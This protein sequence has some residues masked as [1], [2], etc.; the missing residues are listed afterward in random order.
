MYW[1]F[2][3]DR[4]GIKINKRISLLLVTV[5]AVLCLLVVGMFSPSAASKL[6]SP[7]NFTLNTVDNTV[8]ISWGEVD[9]A[10]SYELF[11]QK[12]GTTWQSVVVEG[13]KHTFT[14][15]SPYDTYFFQIRAIDAEKNYG[16]FSSVK[17]RQAKALLTSPRNFK[18]N[19]VDD[20]VEIT[21]DEVDDADKYELF[22]QQA[23]TGWH[24]VIVE[25]TA[26]T[27]TDVSPYYTYFFQIRALDKNGYPGYYSSVNKRAATQKLPSPK[28]LSAKTNDS[29]VSLTWDEVSEARNYELFYLQAGTG[30]HSVIVNGTSHTLKNINPQST[31]YFQIRAVAD[32][33]NPGYYSPVTKRL[34]TPSVG[35]LRNFSNFININW[36]SAP[37][38][39]MYYLWYKTSLSDKWVCAPKPTANTY[40]NISN[41]KSGVVFD[42]EIHAVFPNNDYTVSSVKSVTRLEAPTYGVNYSQND[43]FNIHWN[44]VSGADKYELVRFYNNKSQR[45]YTGSN[46]YFEDNGISAIGPYYYQVRALNGNSQGVWSSYVPVHYVPKKLAQQKIVELAHMQYGNKGDKYWK[47][48]WKPDQWCAM[49]AGWLLREARVDLGKYGWHVNVGVWADNLKAKKQWHDRGKYTPKAGDIIIFGRPDFRTHVGIVTGVKNGIV[50]TSE[51]NATGEEYFNSR[52]TEKSYSL[53]SSYIV[54]YGSVA[55]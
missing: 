23:G 53:N 17:T 13:A 32:K 54:G 6:P 44:K 51:G 15:V 5:S 19:T 38:A 3:T 25:S 39:R 35:A 47:A 55:Y 30:W 8:E 27:F 40:W 28:N 49:Y 21:W 16:Y 14:D 2:L 31:Y 52:V 50:Y 36:T 42:V 33:E 46:T 9:N 20:T 22:Y 29:T 18:A 48:M 1:E 37:G 4:G 41:P 26:H 24:S 34:P 11:F 10:S 7:A 43:R 12:E 45:I